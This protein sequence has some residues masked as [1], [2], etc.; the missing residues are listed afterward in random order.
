MLERFELIIGPGRTGRQGAY[1][2]IRDGSD[3][4]LLGHAIPTHR[5]GWLTPRGQSVLE[6]PDGSLLTSVEQSWWLAEP[7]I[8]DAER[9]LVATLHQRCLY[10]PD[11][12]MLAQLRMLQDGHG[13]FLNLAGGEI[14]I[15]QT[16][17]DGTRLTYSP[18]VASEPLM[19]MALLGAILFLR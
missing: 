16:Q 13:A 15:W 7:R 17:P 9:N 2:P 14:G 4:S 19:K 11:G 1:R 12:R 3:L 5:F 6:E 10:W 18:A 8:L